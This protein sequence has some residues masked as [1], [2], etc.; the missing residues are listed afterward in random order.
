MKTTP[1]EHPIVL[2]L[3]LLASGACSAAPTA[4]VPSP[5]GTGDSDGAAPIVQPGA[6][7][8]D[9]RTF[10]PEEISEVEGVSYTEA[11]V[12]F[13]QGMIP[14]HRQAL[15]MTDLVREHATT[16]AVRRMALRM[17]ISQRDEIALMETWLRNHGEAVAI[18][19]MD[20]GDHLMPG[21][22]TDE[23]MEELR[24][25]RGIEFDRLFLE[26]MIQHHL[27]AI[28]MVATLFATPG[29]AQE[30]TVFKF[31][32][33]VDADQTMEIERMQRVLA[34]LR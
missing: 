1:L 3:S 26:Y 16:E 23:Q 9:A 11:D 10:S 32:E 27:G 8:E 2:V 5:A 17:E 12:H 4:E 24:D 6:P 29:A 30:S 19:G 34:D 14:H 15:V 33:D 22:L 7:G 21:M 13:M 31:A 25:A 28:E 18:P 20:H